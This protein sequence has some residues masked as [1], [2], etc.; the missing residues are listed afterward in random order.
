MKP[1]WWMDCKE[2]ADKSVRAL[3]EG[4]KD[5]HGEQKLTIVPEFH[6][7]TWYHWLENIQEWCISRQLWWGHRIP[8][9]KVV[10]P[11]QQEEVWVTAR[12]LEE[13]KKKAAE[14]LK[15]KAKDVEVEQDPD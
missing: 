12:S 5:E 11:K 15:L 9:Y 10:K 1:Q 3:R 6:H 13:G 2:L 7:Q 14:K 4:L 8:A